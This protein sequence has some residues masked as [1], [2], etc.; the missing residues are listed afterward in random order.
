M[1]KFL[2]LLLL[3][4]HTL[5]WFTKSIMSQPSGAYA[6]SS[7]DTTDGL[8]LDA[9]KYHLPEDYLSQR[10]SQ[11]QLL[12]ESQHDSVPDLPDYPSRVAYQA[13]STLPRIKPDRINEF[14]ACTPEMTAEFVK[15]WL[16]TG[17]GKSKRINRDG[18]LT[19]RRAECWKGFQQ[20]ANAKDGKLGVMCNKCRTV[21]T[22][23]ATNH[24]GTSSMQKHLDGPRCRRQLPK[25][26][27][28]SIRQLLSGA[29][30]KRPASIFTQ[31]VWEQMC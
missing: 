3:S 23:P 18:N 6:S 10:D 26:G 11:N 27:A 30:E 20:V 15:W 31:E 2:I 29:A 22:H 8:P 1:S 9:L 21:L 16:D 14:I 17:Y 7:F 19:N 25:K 13:P 28:S 4:N 24:T 5:Y 12:S